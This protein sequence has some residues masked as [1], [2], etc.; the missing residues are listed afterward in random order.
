[1]HYSDYLREQ[2]AEYR[3][4]ADVAEDPARPF[5]IGSDL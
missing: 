5:R 3:R 2:A 1:M 4:L